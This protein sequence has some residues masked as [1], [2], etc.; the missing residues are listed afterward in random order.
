MSRR[1]GVDFHFV[2]ATKPLEQMVRA[3]RDQAGLWHSVAA[4][5]KRL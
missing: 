5:G 1:F 3:E 2:I 4:E